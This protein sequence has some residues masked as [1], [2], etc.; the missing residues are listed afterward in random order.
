MPDPYRP[1]RAYTERRV[2]RQP[3]PNNPDLAR[4]RRLGMSPAALDE[5]MRNWQTMDDTDK[6]LY[7][8]ASRALSDA[9]LGE[10][11]TAHRAAS[12]EGMEAAE[13]VAGVAEDVVAWV[14]NDPARAEAAIAAERDRRRPRTTLIRRLEALTDG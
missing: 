1:A 9:E 4:L 6:A 13:V 5:A 11:I 8:E 3:L 7:L 14:G 12:V 2:A 10:Q